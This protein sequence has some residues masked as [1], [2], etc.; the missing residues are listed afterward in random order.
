MREIK[1]GKKKIPVFFSHFSSQA[2]LGEYQPVYEEFGYILLLVL[3]LIH[4]YSFSA[5]DIAFSH[6][7]NRESFVPRLLNQ[8]S[9]AQRLEALDSSE[10]HAQLGGWIKELFEDEGISNG[11]MMSCQPQ[12]FYRLVPTLF[13]Q[14]MMA[15]QRGV[16]DLETVKG[17]FSFLLV[18]F[19]LPSVISGLSWLSQYLW[20][21]LD[22]NPYPILQ[23]LTSLVIAHD[24]TPEAAETQRTVVSISA[25]PLDSVLRELLRRP[26]IAPEVASAAQQLLVHL[27]PHLHFQ[28][29]GSPTR[30]E[31]GSWVSHSQVGPPAGIAATLASL[32][33]AM[34]LWSLPGEPA[35]PRPPT[36]MYTSRLILAAHRL[37]GARLVVD[38]ILHEAA[39]CR[40]SHQVPGVAEDVAVALLTVFIPDEA[41][42]MTLR[43]ALRAVEE[44]LEDSE[45]EAGSGVGASAAAGEGGDTGPGAGTG[46]GAGTGTG[47]GYREVALEI[48]RRVDAARRPWIGAPQGQPGVVLGAMELGVGLEE[49]AGMDLMMGGVGVGEFDGGMDGMLDVGMDM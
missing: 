12:G 15:L 26:A 4:R 31:M 33:S 24:I 39:K 42:G 45:T 16:L 21:N 9:T 30:D 25:R 5:A 32:Y 34:F 28:R 27:K 7:V 40:A 36:T 19:L 14:S 3:T 10:H 13:A 2:C 44:E 6:E 46:A 49:D 23:I 48:I 35:S 22:S 11:L 17:A 20:S 37:L 29:S 18:P 43:E 47:P 8:F 1:V 41:R 38:V